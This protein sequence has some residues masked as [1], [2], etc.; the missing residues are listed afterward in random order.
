M[1]AFFFFLFRIFKANRSLWLVGTSGEEI[2]STT[3]ASSKMSGLFK[4][5][6]EAWFIG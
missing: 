6:C 4:D 2:F 5:S 3:L 1:V